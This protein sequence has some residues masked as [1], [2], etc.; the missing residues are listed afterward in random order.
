VLHH[1]TPQKHIYILEESLKALYPGGE[2]IVQTK[3]ELPVKKLLTEVGFIHVETIAV[4]E[5]YGRTAWKA[6]KDPMKV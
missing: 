4:Q 6:I 1:I 5:H 3:S 2:I